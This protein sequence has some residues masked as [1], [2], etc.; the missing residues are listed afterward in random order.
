MKNFWIISALLMV[1]VSACSKDEFND[2]ENVAQLKIRLTDAPV[3]YD[4]VNVE[5]LEVRVHTSEEGWVSLDTESGIYNL[6]DYTD[7]LDTLIAGDFVP[8]GLVSQIRLVLGEANNVVID[9]ISYPLEIPSGSTSGLKLNV[10]E[11]LIGGLSYTMTLDFDAALSA[12]EHGN[13][14][15]HLKPVIRV[16][17]TSVSGAIEGNIQP[18]VQCT[19]YAIS[20]EDTLSTTSNL[21][22]DFLLQAVPAGTWT[23]WVDAPEPYNDVT[24]ENVNVTNGVVTNVGELQIN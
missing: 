19:V 13:G 5:I 12:V 2:A 16:L 24:V 11:T 23:V 6:L 22:G 4:S 20:G 14:D 8:A 18:P 3:N 17:P 9:G 15:Y 21:L 1:L 7:G 10:H